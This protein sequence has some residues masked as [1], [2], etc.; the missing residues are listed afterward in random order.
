M[1]EENFFHDM[2]RKIAKIEINK[3]RKLNPVFDFKSLIILKM[4][5]LYKYFD[6]ESDHII[7]LIYDFEETSAIHHKEFYS[8]LENE[9]DSKKLKENLFHLIDVYFDIVNIYNNEIIPFYRISD[10]YNNDH[11]LMLGF[12]DITEQFFIEFDLP[13]DYIKN[14]NEKRI[15]NENELNKKYKMI[16][17]LP[18]HKWFNKNKKRD[19]MC[20]STRIKNFITNSKNDETRREKQS[21]TR[22]NSFI[23]EKNDKNDKNEDRTKDLRIKSQCIVEQNKAIVK[24]LEQ[25]SH[26]ENN[27]FRSMG[28]KGFIEFTTDVFIFSMSNETINTINDDCSNILNNHNIYKLLS[29]FP[30]L[31]LNGEI[32]K[33]NFELREPCTY[34]GYQRGLDSKTNMVSEYKFSNLFLSVPEKSLWNK[35]KNKELEEVIKI[36]NSDIEI[37]FDSKGQPKINI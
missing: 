22:N 8:F 21:D 16:F 2:T 10:S 29:F 11:S 30:Q 28:F 24:A 17:E 36:M 31:A 7:D 25:N 6:I 4:K 20:H 33:S 34:F 12:K 13:S 19:L 35:E 15:Q 23:I 32:G 37:I 3:I 26:F 9:N 27:K 1:N 5:N 18:E 14:I